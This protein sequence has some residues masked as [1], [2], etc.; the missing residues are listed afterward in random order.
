[1]GCVAVMFRLPSSQEIISQVVAVT[2]V[3]CLP[4]PFLVSNYTK[5]FIKILTFIGQV[6]FELSITLLDL[7]ETG[8]AK[9]HLT[10]T[11][12]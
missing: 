8:L 3:F 2:I 1:M 10:W 7:S 12:V 5:S 9:W 6:I 4:L 11:C